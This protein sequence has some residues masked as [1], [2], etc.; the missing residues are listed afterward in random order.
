MRFAS[1]P[2]FARFARAGFSRFAFGCVSFG[3]LSFCASALRD[4]PISFFQ[5]G[6]FVV[7]LP[8]LQ[9]HLRQP[10]LRQRLLGLEAGAL[11]Q[12]LELG[13]R[14][15]ALMATVFVITLRSVSSASDCS[16]VCMPRDVLVC[17]TE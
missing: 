17:M 4:R 7:V 14:L 15:V 8:S 5:N 9:A 1:E 2:P 13:A 11:E 12:R 10:Q 16:S 6:C 3:S